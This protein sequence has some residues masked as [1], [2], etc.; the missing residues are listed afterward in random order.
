MATGEQLDEEKIQEDSKDES[1]VTGAHFICAWRRKASYIENNV[2][3]IRLKLTH[4][5]ETHRLQF[6]HFTQRLFIYAG[7]N[8]TQHNE[9]LGYR[10]PHEVDQYTR[11]FLTVAKWLQVSIYLIGLIKLDEI[12]LHF[13]QNSLC[14]TKNVRLDQPALTLM[15]I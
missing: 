2:E 7:T 4:R 10:S 8:K 13:S 6:V 9:H 15:K 5:G 3:K 11:R 12:L 14:T 1:R